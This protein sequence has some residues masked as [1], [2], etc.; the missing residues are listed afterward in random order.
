LVAD[1]RRAAE[2]GIR[3]HDLEVDFL[4]V[5]DRARGLVA[6]AKV[7]LDAAQLAEREDPDVA[8]VLQAALELDGCR[9]LLNVKVQ[10]IEAASLGVRMHLADG[11]VEG[12]H[13]FLATGR[14]PNTDDLGLETVG[15]ELGDHGTVQVNDRLCTNLPGLW[16]VGDIRGGPAFTH[17]AYDDFRFA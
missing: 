15:V 7:E 6:K 2:L 13:L 16:A 9:V 5:M 1:A 14:Q 17:T 8:E 10:R 4:A 11:S 3:I 12:S